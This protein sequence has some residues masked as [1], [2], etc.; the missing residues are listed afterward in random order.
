MNISIWFIFCVFI[1]CGQ[2]FYIVHIISSVCLVIDENFNQK[3]AYISEGTS[4]HSYGYLTS[5]LI[6]IFE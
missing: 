5:R 3:K 2:L 4:K 1:Y 6:K